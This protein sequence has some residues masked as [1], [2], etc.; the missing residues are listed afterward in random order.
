MGLWFRKKT[1][2]PDTSQQ[3]SNVMTQPDVEVA[4]AP[5]APAPD[6]VASAPTERP[7]GL[8][9]FKLPPEAS[10]PAEPAPPTTTPPVTPPAAVEL[11]H[12]TP[13]PQ[14][15]PTAPTAPSPLKPVLK[16]IPSQPRIQ[17]AEKPDPT[18]KKT[19]SVAADMPPVSRTDPKALYYQLMN[20]LYDVI[21]VLDDNG[22]IIDCNTRAEEIFGYSSDDVWNM[23]IDKIVYGMNNRMF[24][25]LKN[26]LDNRRH[27]LIDARCFRS[28]GTSFLG[29]VGVS[30]VQLTRS[31]SIVFAIRNTERRKN[32]ADELRKYR[33]LID[34]LPIP[35]FV[36]DLHGVLEIMNTPV[37][38]AFGM[39]DEMEAR[40]KHISEMLPNIGDR[41]Q[42][43]VRGEEVSETQEMLRPDGSSGTLELHLRPLRK[44][45][46]I[47][48][49]A[50]TMVF[51]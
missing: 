46:E 23:S 27:I 6:P 13:T 5:A 26:N 24:S 19:E 31:K 42:A 8:R 7:A 11:P 22:H 38:K 25:L 18:N 41:F 43:V 4:P 47:T 21:L 30:T 17:V 14:P 2:K 40:K 49:I 20:G 16:P 35:A 34:M 48:G 45:D 10:A 32:S 3:N 15:V 36:C 51:S 33:A 9:A 28:N 50:G 37:L 12:S 44:G 1:P 29:E 39:V